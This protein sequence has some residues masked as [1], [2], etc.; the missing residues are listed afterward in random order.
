MAPG[1]REAVGPAAVR[2]RSQ[3]AW[4][5]AALLGLA[6]PTAAQA[7]EPT[8]LL[9]GQSPPPAKTESK[10]HRSLNFASSKFLQRVSGG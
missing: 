4:P 2:W 1:A 3:A 6:A 10:F 8:G 5:L 9:T 7:L